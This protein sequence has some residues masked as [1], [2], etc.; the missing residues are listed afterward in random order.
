MPVVLG[1]ALDMQAI[2]GGQATHDTIDAHKIAVLRRGGMLPQASIDP[3]ER[4]AT[5]DVLRRRMPRRRTRAERLAH[6]P[7]TTRHDNLPESSTNL[8]SKANRA[9]MAERFPEAAVHTS[10][11]VALALLETDDCLLTDLA[12]DLVKPATRH[13]APTC[14]R[15]RSLPGVGTSLALVLRYESHE[16]HRCPRVQ[17]LVSYGCL[18]T[19]AH[20]SAGQ[21]SGASGTKMGHASLKGACSE[22]AVLFLRH[23]PA[24]QKS[25]ARLERQQGQGNAVTILAHQLARAVYDM[26]KRD[27]AFAGDTCLSESCS[28]GSEPAASRA[29]EG[30]SLT[31]TC[32]Q[33]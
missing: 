33:P 26:R 10:I 11:A 21:R 9:H 20:A 19:C 3:A 16:I 4:R 25:R 28:R 6:G 7:Q 29:A 32:W 27:T 23:N 8:A 15:L 12:R 30:I 24:G 5:R 14:S 18:V 1:H 2:P 13:E 31:I 17:E 22:A